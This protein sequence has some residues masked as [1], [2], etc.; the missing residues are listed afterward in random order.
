M[1][2]AMAELSHQLPGTTLIPYP[3]VTEHQR[4]TPWWKSMT[5]TKTV[6]FEYLKYIVA[7]VRMRLD[8]VVQTAEADVVLRGRIAR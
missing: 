7:V 1:P 3:V 5:S 2:R 4:M 6:V 8:P